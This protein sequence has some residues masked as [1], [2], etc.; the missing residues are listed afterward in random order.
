MK[1]TFAISYAS[2]PGFPAGSVV[3]HIRVTV[4]GSATPAQSQNVSPGTTQVVFDPLAADSYSYAVD[5]VDPSGAVLSSRGGS[6]TVGTAAP[7]ST[8]TLSV[9]GGVTVT[10]Y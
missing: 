3:D 10:V 5:T 1:A 9:P 7:P 6:F 8:V 2:L 4:T